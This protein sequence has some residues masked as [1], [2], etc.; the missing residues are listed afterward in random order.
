[1][2]KYDKDAP[3]ADPVLRCDSCSSIV[4]S[5]D[6]KKYG[7]CPDCGNRKVRNLQVFSEKEHET[8][9]EWSVDPEFLAQF[10]AT[11]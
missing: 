1:M 10:E 6:L 5:V 4:L 7:R 3:F 11:E 2:N 8:M 9:L